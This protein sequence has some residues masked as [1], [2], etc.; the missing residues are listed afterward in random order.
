MSYGGSSV[1]AMCIAISL[2]LRV[3][4]ERRLIEY[5]NHKKAVGN[6]KDVDPEGARAW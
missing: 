3:D 6:K 5:D 4:Y 2:L 1:L